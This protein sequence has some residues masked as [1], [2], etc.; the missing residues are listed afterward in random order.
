M[1]RHYFDTFHKGFPITVLLGWDRPMDYYFLVV[2]KPAELIDDTMKV[3]SDDFL[4]SNLHESDPFNHGLDYYR[5]V[6]RHFQ[7]GVPESMFIQVQ[8]DR[9]SYTGNRVAKHQTDG[10]FTEREL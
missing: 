8:R 9:E 4:Y 5:E 2:E 3:E 1:S 10:S 6:L 7:I